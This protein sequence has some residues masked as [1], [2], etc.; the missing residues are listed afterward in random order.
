MRD[1][2][3]NER[4]REEEERG[5]GGLYCREFTLNSHKKYLAMLQ[6]CIDH[7][8]E[9]KRPDQTEQERN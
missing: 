1:E 2:A 8:R 5:R 9:K 6:M 3:G 7:G 4:E